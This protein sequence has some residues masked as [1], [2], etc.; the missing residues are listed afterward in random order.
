MKTVTLENGKEIVTPRMPKEMYLR[1][2][3]QGKEINR[4]KTVP[5]RHDS[6]RIIAEQLHELE[7]ENRDLCDCMEDYE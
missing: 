6:R 1:L 4:K 5:N 7:E 2:R 3:T